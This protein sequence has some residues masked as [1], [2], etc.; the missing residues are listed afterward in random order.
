MSR[1]EVKLF[2]RVL[3]LIMAVSLLSGCTKTEDF[4]SSVLSRSEALKG[5]T[6]FRFISLTYDD[7]YWC[8]KVKYTNAKQETTDWRLFYI[9]EDYSG[10]YSI[11]ILEEGESGLKSLSLALDTHHYN[12]SCKETHSNGYQNK[13]PKYVP[14]YM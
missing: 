8:G 7:D 2:R 11:S 13:A 9:R 4:L 12:Q 6:S 10:G 3:S 5:M 1:I 14:F